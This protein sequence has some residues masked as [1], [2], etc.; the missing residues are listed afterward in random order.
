MTRHP[1]TSQQIDDFRRKFELL[2]VA[3]TGKIDR[4][5]MAEI[6]K[7]EG[8]QLESLMIVL[9][10]EKFDKDNDG[11]ISF[12]EFITFCSEIQDL[13]DV[14]ILRQIFDLADVDHSQYLELEEVV[15]I[16]KMMGL[17]V[18]RAD[19]WETIKAL[20]VDGNFLIDFNEFCQII[21]QA[22]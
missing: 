13:S 14:A 5:T 16:G 11:Y 20:D 4:E 21:Q 2:D 9:L 3:K 10:F 15:K 6:M 18:S 8:E 1:F 22:Q 19:A 17:H 7:N 12:E